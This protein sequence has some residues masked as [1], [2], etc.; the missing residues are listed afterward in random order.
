MVWI[1]LKL[2]LIT[3]KVL[4]DPNRD[5]VLENLALRHQPCR[6]SEGALS[7]ASRLRSAFLVIP[8]QELDWVAR[9]PCP[10]PTRNCSSL[11]PQSLAK[12]LDLEE[13]PPGT[14]P[15]APLAASPRAHSPNGQG[16]ST[17][18]SCSRRR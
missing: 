5:L 7:V 6:L 15:A 3:L 10:R 11:A 4:G 13:P 8:R 14:R 16:E 2:L 1:L 12:V 18:G 17:L 9:R